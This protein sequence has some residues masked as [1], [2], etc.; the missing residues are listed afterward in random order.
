MSPSRRRILSVRSGKRSFKVPAR[1]EPEEW[2][3]LRLAAEREGRSVTGQ[4]SWLI[5]RYLREPGSQRDR[6]EPV[7]QVRD[8]GA[9]RDDSG[10]SDYW[11]SRPG[12]ERVAEAFRLSRLALSLAGAPSGSARIDAVGRVVRKSP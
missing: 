9:A 6:I 7:L 2:A 3:A 10:M 11:L 4:V 8:A 5:R 1:L 12:N